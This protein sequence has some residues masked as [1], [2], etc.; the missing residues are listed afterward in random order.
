[1]FSSYKRQHSV[2]GKNVGSS[3]NFPGPQTNLLPVHLLN[4]HASSL[5]EVLIFSSVKQGIIVKTATY[6]REFMQ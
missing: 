2:V 6:I 1:M 5:L 4:L 3:A